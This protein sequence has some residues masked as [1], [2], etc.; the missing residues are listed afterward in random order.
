M[1]KSKEEKSSEEIEEDE[2]QI[3]AF[4]R[5][6][7][8]L[9]AADPRN[10]GDIAEAAGI[11]PK[12]LSDKLIGKTK[13]LTAADVRKLAKALRVD[14]AVLLNP[15]TKK[16][17]LALAKEREKSS[18]A[19]GKEA[20]G[21]EPTTPEKPGKLYSLPAAPDYS[22]AEANGLLILEMVEQAD[23]RVEIPVWPE[24]VAATALASNDAAHD[25]KTVWVPA[26]LAK[27]HGAKLR[28]IEVAGR[29]MVG[30]G[31]EPGDIAFARCSSDPKKAQHK[32]VIAYQDGGMTLK[33]LHGD[34]L[35]AESDRSYPRIQ[36]G[37]DAQMQGVVVGLHKPK[38]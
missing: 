37:D 22:L 32:I 8:L 2:E 1:P 3:L 15:V 7:D 38:R 21:T 30:A 18:Q 27:I 10:Q 19:I 23:D 36:L 26:R 17:L 34:V 16:K 24:S 14:A 25:Q 12:T 6:I 4:V 11:K 29:S 9:I 31:I 13:K 5:M 28:A 33:R 35:E 20:S